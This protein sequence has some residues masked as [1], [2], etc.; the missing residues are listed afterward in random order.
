[1]ENFLAAARFGE[2]ISFYPI[3]AWMLILSVIA[4]LYRFARLK[5]IFI[6]TALY[7]AI[8][9][10]TDWDPSEAFQAWG[11]KTLHPN[12]EFDARPEYFFHSGVL[13]FL[14]GYVHYHLPKWSEVK[15]FIG[16]MVGA[17][18]FVI[19]Y[20][21][22]PS[23]HVDP[24]YIFSTEHAMA[25]STMGLFSV[26]GIQLFVLCLFLWL[27]RKNIKIKMPFI[28]WLGLNSLAVF[29]SHR[30]VFI[31]LYGPCLIF[32]GAMFGFVPTMGLHTLW[33]P[34]FL[35]AAFVYI[36]KKK[37]IHELIFR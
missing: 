27:E 26:W 23:F 15:D 9:L 4:T 34:I 11:Q 10:F 17:I 21:F 31:H 5:G 20:F 35:T 1:V 37:K 2:A 18:I 32:L 33:P 24:Y 16:M 12:F 6:F 19:Y 36:I 13:G 3:M 29:A 28:N 8:Y 30:I 14:L 25:E 7:S 22:G